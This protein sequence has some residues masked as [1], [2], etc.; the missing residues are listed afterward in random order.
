M[1]LTKI[2]ISHQHVRVH[3]IYSIRTG[4]DD[5]GRNEEVRRG[6]RH[7]PA[8]DR[9]R[10]EDDPGSNENRTRGGYRHVPSGSP[11]STK[12]DSNRPGQTENAFHTSSHQAPP[13]EQIDPRRQCSHRTEQSQNTIPTTF[14]QAPPCEQSYQTRHSSHRTRQGENT[15]NTHRQAPPPE[16]THQTGNFSHRTRRGDHTPDHPSPR[17]A[18]A[19]SREQ[20]HQREFSNYSHTSTRPP[21]AP[22]GGDL[23]KTLNVSPEASHA[24]IVCAARRRRI[25]VHPDRLKYPGMTQSALDRIDDEAQNVGLAADTLCDELS[26]RRYDRAVRRGSR[27]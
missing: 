8:R 12:P 5:P 11:S 13:R 6:Y 9:A 4:N 15:T 21:V 20:P 27:S 25:Q 3:T 19:P 23:Y 14:C 18:P 2:T 26:R 16:P 24:E 22:R 1:P 10:T 7:I 17:Q